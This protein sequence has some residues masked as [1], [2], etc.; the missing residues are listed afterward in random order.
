[1]HQKAAVCTTD[2]ISAAEPPLALLLDE[3]GQTSRASTRCLLLTSVGMK[4]V[5]VC[6]NTSQCE[7]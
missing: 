4:N 5:C 6:I 7:L 3:A 1:M 2:Y